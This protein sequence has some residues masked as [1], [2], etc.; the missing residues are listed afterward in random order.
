MRRTLGSMLAGVLVLAGLALAN[1]A[2]AAGWLGVYSQD[3]TPELRDGMNYNGAGALVTRVVPDSPADRGGV[4]RGDVIV[5]VGA[6]DIG[7]PEQLIDVVG[8]SAAGSTIDLLVV[9]DGAKKSLRATLAS[10]P[11]SGDSEEAPPMPH[12]RMHMTTPEAPHGHVMERHRLESGDAD[13]LLSQLPQMLGG[14]MAG[15]GRLGVRIESLSPDLASYFGPRDSMGALVLEVTDGSP[16]E[17][18]GIRAGDVITR[19]DGKPVED[20]GDAISAVRSGEGTV[21]ISLLR[22]GAKQTVEADLGKAPKLMRFESGPQGM[23]WR[24]Q[25]GNTWEWQGPDGKGTKR[26]IIHSGDGDD[27]DGDLPGD[28]MH[29]RIVIE[30]DGPAMRHGMS[31]ARESMDSLREEVEQLREQLEQLRKE[32]ESN[33]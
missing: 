22:H 5:Q 20:A 14:A 2:G 21:S 25:G 10:R 19:L 18:A 7:S 3:I 28:G 9:R 17:K 32:L 11:D 6:R 13:E 30:G 8:A 24:Q 12:M 31:A 15:R 4:E 23:N 33:R 29:R 1:P 16:A 27:P 26:I